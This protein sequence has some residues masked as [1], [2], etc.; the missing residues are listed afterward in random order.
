MLLKFRVFKKTVGY[1]EGWSA[2]VATVDNPIRPNHWRPFYFSTDKLEVD[3]LVALPL[4]FL[5]DPKDVI[6]KYID[7][8]C[9]L[10]GCGLAHIETVDGFMTYSNYRINPVVR[11]ERLLK[12]LPVGVEYWYSGDSDV[13][14]CGDQAFSV[15][16]NN[17]KDAVTA[18]IEDMLDMKMDGIFPEKIGEILKA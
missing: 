14:I 9:S 1:V 8:Y 10:R 16:K 6:T 4:Q 11:V 18:Y 13:F 17:R 3:N 5:P 15:F 12:A 7:P 2:V